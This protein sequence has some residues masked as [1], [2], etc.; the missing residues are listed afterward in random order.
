MLPLGVDEATALVITD[1]QQAELQPPTY[2]FAPTQKTSSPVSIR[3]LLVR[4][5]GI[6]S[7]KL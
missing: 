3:H 1:T 7:I 4:R 2:A 6:A 5:I